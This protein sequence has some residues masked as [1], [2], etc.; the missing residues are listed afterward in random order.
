M[1]EP[2]TIRID[3]WHGLGPRSFSEESYV[4][5]EKSQA[6]FD[7]IWSV[8]NNPDEPVTRP[9]TIKRGV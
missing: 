2:R 5:G 7:Y 6:E 1:D 9:S 3:N 8:Q 4:W